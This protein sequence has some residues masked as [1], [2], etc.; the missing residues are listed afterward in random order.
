MTKEQ[1]IKFLEERPAISLSKL[2]EEAGYSAGRQLRNILNGDGY[3]TK[4]VEVRLRP[5][6]KKYGFK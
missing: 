6:V 2:G 5:V 1:F 4:E 3:W